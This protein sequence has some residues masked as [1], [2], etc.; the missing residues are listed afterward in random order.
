MTR[1]L[2]NED[3]SPSSESNYQ[4]LVSGCDRTCTVF[5]QLYSIMA[6]GDTTKVFKRTILTAAR[7]TRREL[8]H[9]SGAGTIM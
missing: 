1:F 4:L 7:T 2:F 3:S 5:G 9:G 6:S 8:R